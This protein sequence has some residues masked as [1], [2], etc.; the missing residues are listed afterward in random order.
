MFVPDSMPFGGDYDET[1]PSDI[2]CEDWI[3]S[4]PMQA[5]LNRCDVSEAASSSGSLQPAEPLPVAEGVKD[6]GSLGCAMGMVIKMI[7]HDYFKWV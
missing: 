5:L 1:L 6:M 7:H 3:H 2:P 4:A